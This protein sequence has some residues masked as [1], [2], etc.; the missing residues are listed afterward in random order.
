MSEFKVDEWIVR[1]NDS[2]SFPKEA[3][4][5]VTMACN[6]NC[7][8]CF[9]RGTDET[10]GVMDEKHFQK[11]IETAKK[12]EVRKIVFSGWGEPLT[13]SKILDFIGLAKSAGFNVILNTNGVLL[14]NYAEDL[15]ELGV[16]EIVV[17]ID[18]TDVEVY[19]KLRIGGKVTE[20]IK[21][22]QSLHEIQMKKH[23]L[24]K[25]GLEFTV[26][27]LNYNQIPKVI[28]LADRVKASYI[29]LSNIVPLHEDLEEIA[30][31]NDDKCLKEMEKS[32]GVIGKL[33]L[34]RNVNVYRINLTIKSQ[35]M[36]PFMVNNALYVRWDGN[37]A[38][39]IHYAHNHDIILFGIRRRLN[40]VIFG[41]IRDEELVN[42]WRN[43][44][45]AT[46][47][48]RTK[49]GYVPSCLDC[50]L[51]PYC[52]FTLSN[53]MDCWGN[54]PTCAHCPFLYGLAACPL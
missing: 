22:L 8:Y 48:F 25:L 30:C 17:S 45:Y 6:L 19:G 21:G 32:Y 16:D 1:V 9:R 31:Y 42:I 40:K 3:M 27:R 13:H 41:N 28:E 34:E 18:A 7:I 5:E 24:L 4:V 39:C 36:C 43:V 33:V 23:R 50:E 47:R 26:T 52:V 2:V 51:A 14:Y 54:S 11:L 46:F 44:K 15:V 20:V 37:V 10:F 35:R 29:R 53:E 38:P 49:Y 12:S